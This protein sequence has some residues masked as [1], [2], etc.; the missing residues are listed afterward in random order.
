MKTSN[1]LA[2]VLLASASAL[3]LS[4]HARAE[5]SPSFVTSQPSGQWRIKNFVGKEITN[6]QNEKIGDVND[7][8]FDETG[9]ISIVVLGVGGFLGVGEKHVAV[10]YESL[11][12]TEKD[13]ARALSIAVTKGQLQ[14]A[15]AFVP[16][17]KTRLEVVREKAGEYADKAKEKAG[18]LKDKAIE[19]YEE[20]RKE[21]PK[22]Q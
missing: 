2:A 3:P 4:V 5:A 22:S 6:E 18:E 16:T 14:N 15:P 17:E 12:Y 21:T 8:L 11:R 20:L 19:K 1:L 7:V 10:P 9:K 13:G